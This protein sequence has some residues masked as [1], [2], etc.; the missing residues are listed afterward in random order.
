MLYTPTSLT[1][2]G[3]DSCKWPAWQVVSR[4]CSSQESPGAKPLG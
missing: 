4:V 3:L 2:R 1:T